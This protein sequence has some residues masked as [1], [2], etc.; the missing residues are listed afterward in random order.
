[1]PRWV[2]KKIPL[3]E[4]ICPGCQ[5]PV[6]RN[7]YVERDGEATLIWHYGCHEKR[8]AE[9]SKVRVH[10]PHV[11]VVESDGRLGPAPGSKLPEGGR[12]E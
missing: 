9:N 11:R 10:Y 4:R 12:W 2:Y 5:N 8:K 6:Q 7:A 3:E 1:M